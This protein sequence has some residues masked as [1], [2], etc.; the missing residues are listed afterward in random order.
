MDSSHLPIPNPSVEIVNPANGYIHNT[1]VDVNGQFRAAGLPVGTYELH[2]SAP[3]FSTYTQTGINLAVDQTVRLTVELV[4]A[5]VQAAITVTTL[6][7]PLD[8]AQTS[9]TSVIDHER[10]EELPV[11]TRNALD[12]VLLAPGVSPAS[13]QSG[14][15][16]SGTFSTSGFTFGGL[17]AGSNNISIDGLDNND[18]F[19]GASRTELSPEIVSEFQ[20]VNNGISAEFGGASGGSVN[21]VTRSGTNEMHGDAFVFAQNGALNARSPI[22]NEFQKP[23]LRR[24]RTGFANGGAMQKNQTFTTLPSNRNPSTRRM[25]PLSIP[26]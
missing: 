22:G 2:A 3:G 25:N 14:S 6:P 10:I 7:S 18:E 17:R 24:Y 15:G 20:I 12:F 26:H 23:D 16:S 11:R 13:T 1:P 21:V 5:Q 4:L 19:S 8:V 9:V